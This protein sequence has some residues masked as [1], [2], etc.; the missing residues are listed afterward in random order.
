MN[1]TQIAWKLVGLLAMLATAAVPVYVAYDLWSRGPAPEKKVE[2]NRLTPIDPLR[3]L[4]SL[5]ERVSLSLQVEHQTINNL[6]IAQAFIENVG[7][8]PILPSDYTQPL[9]VSVKTPWKIVAV[10]NSK[11]FSSASVQL[12]WKRVDDF[13]FEA[14]PALLNPTDRIAT[15][16]YLTN[17]R[18]TVGEGSSSDPK[19]EVEWKARIVN[20]RSFYEPPSVFDRAVQQSWGINVDLSG[21]ALLFTLGATLLFQALYLHLLLRAGF[22]RG[23]SGR[24]IVLVLAASLVSLAA[25]ECIATYLF[26][27]L[28]TALN[29]IDHWLNAPPIGL[30]IVLVSFLYWRARKPPL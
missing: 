23:W 7:K 25:A 22:L 5:G 26:G 28:L 29:G 17:S 14:E 16:I 19:P 24:S 8:T 18:P 21:W 10:A 12:R 2:L 4:S 3:D 9:S 27:N 1:F 15:Y 13:T 20:L 6:V 30:H 11:P